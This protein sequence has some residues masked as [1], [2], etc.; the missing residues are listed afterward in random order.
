MEGEN[1]PESNTKPPN[2]LRLQTDRL[3]RPNPV[4]I[5]NLPPDTIQHAA[6]L[7]RER[8]RRRRRA[9]AQRATVQ[10]RHWL[11]DYHGHHDQRDQNESVH[12]R[13]GKERQDVVQEEDRCDYAV[14]YGDAGLSLSACVRARF[15]VDLAS[16]LGLGHLPR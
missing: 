11:P 13:A 3:R 16:G 1:I 9:A 2:R 5:L 4:L 14:D 6:Q 8:Q 10:I 7:C 15:R 12:A